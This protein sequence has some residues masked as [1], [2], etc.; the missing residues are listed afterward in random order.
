MWKHLSLP[1]SLQYISVCADAASVVDLM[2]QLRGGLAL[3]ECEV[4]ASS[5]DGR[6]GSFGAQI[7]HFELHNAAP[8]ATD[9]IKHEL[10]PRHASLLASPFLHFKLLSVSTMSSMIFE[11]VGI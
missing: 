5:C 9:R 8:S 6:L 11:R 1:P 3:R 4:M 2:L 7:V 10:V